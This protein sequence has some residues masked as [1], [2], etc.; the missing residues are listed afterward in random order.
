MENSVIKVGNGR[1]ISF[2][3]DHWSSNCSLRSMFPRLFDLSVNKESTLKQMID[4]KN[5][6]DGW[7]FLFR[8]VLR[9]WEEHEVGRLRAYLST[10]EPVLAARVDSWV[11]KAS[12][13]G[14]FTVKSLYSRPEAALGVEV[15]RILSWWGMQWV[16]PKNARGV[17]EWWSGYKWVLCVVLLD[18]LQYSCE[19]QRRFMEVCWYL[20]MNVCR[21]SLRSAGAWV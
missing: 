21:L 20:W 6:S 14:M 3:K 12:T 9:A 19:D 7:S 4:R 15:D 16:I 11:W 2:W 18:L 13:S 8:R 17:L 5:S 10:H 1:R